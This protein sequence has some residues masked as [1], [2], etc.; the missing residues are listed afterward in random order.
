METVTLLLFL[1]VLLACVALK[2][3][4]LLALAAGYVIFFLYSRKKGFSTREIL[5][6]SWK[7]IQTVRNVLILFLF[8]GMLTALW[9]ACGTIAVIITICVRF[10]QPSAFLLF[11]FL[12]NCGVSVLTGTAFG[13]A[14]TMGVICMSIAGAM[15]LNPVLVGGAV[16]SGVFFGDRCSPVSTS[17]LLVS[18]L[19]GTDL[20]QNIARMVRSALVP[21]CGACA[22]YFALGMSTASGGG[23]LP[24][25]E[26]IFAQGLVLHPAALLPALLVLVLAAFRVPVKRVLAA[27]ILT[28]LVLYLTLQHGSISGLPV[29]LFSGFHLENQQLE[30]LLGGG[31]ILSMVRGGAIVCLSSSYAGIF[32]KTGLLHSLQAKIERLGKRRAFPAVL[33]AGTATALVS[34]NQTLAILLTHQLCGNL[35]D[36]PALALDLE[37]SVVVIAALV[38]WSIAAAVPL[39]SVGAP[40]TSICAA[41]Y[42]YFL[43]IW[44]LVS[45]GGVK[46]AYHTSTSD[47]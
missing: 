40:L 16:L 9:R 43:P 21:F 7:G 41:C 45:G 39:S 20:F 1:G 10:L 25:V 38:P 15:G 31:G 5:Q 4:L 23:A 8:I 3:E 32:E 26:S 44:R 42:L 18:E 13:T 47:W 34:C 33:A 11:A 6:M 19:T 37:D 12:M 35:E 30:A 27:S 14:A 29:L 17:A 2:L 28:A 36:G 46:S 22:V 24:D